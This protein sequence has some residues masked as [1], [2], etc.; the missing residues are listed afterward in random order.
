MGHSFVPLSGNP[1]YGHK[2]DLKDRLTAR[3]PPRWLLNDRLNIDADRPIRADELDE[4]IEETAEQARDRRE[5]IAEMGQDTEGVTATLE[6]AVDSQRL[7]SDVAEHLPLS[8]ERAQRYTGFHHISV[9]GPRLHI[10]VG[11]RG[12]IKDVTLGCDTHH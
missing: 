11:V 8:R 12:G 5:R 6:L 2:G 1:L 10:D 7:P 3:D 4:K 9:R